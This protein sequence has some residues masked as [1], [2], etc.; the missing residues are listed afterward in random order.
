M[1]HKY[2][3]SDLSKRVLGTCPVCGKKRYSSRQAAKRD[4]RRLFPG[5]RM[6]VYQ[7]G[8]SWHI[9]SQTTQQVTEWRAYERPES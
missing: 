1:S 4:A 8:T 5:D 7:C 9:T 6:R 3:M 2:R